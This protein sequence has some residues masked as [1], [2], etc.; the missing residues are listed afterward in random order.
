MEKFNDEFYKNLLD[1]IYDRV[2]EFSYKTLEDGTYAWYINDW[3]QDEGLI[4]YKQIVEKVVGS[5]LQE[6]EDSK[7]RDR[8]LGFL[9]EN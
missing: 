5:F 4:S 1:Y 3:L 9:Y 6:K 8:E 2:Y 7:R